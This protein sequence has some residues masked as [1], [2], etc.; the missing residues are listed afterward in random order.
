MAINKGKAKR[1]ESFTL[2][3][4]V[5]T[6]LGG[7]PAYDDGISGKTEIRRDGVCGH[8]DH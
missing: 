4:T 5:T 6:A 7:N 8:L 2:S 3:D 1:K